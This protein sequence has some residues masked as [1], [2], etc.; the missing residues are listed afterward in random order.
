M[1]AVV[2]HPSA[3]LAKFRAITARP[4]DHPEAVV[5]NAC[6]QLMRYGDWIDHERGRALLFAIA[7][8]GREELNRRARADQRR[9]RILRMEAIAAAIAVLFTALFVLFDALGHLIKSI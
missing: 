7:E 2:D 8:R 9:R 4:E 3:N 5:L 6:E 1:G